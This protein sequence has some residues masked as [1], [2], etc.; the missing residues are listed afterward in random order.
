VEGTHRITC[1]LISEN[2]WEH[3]YYLRD[4]QRFELEGTDNTLID[5]HFSIPIEDMLSFIGDVEQE[6]GTY[7]DGY[8]IKITPK[9]NGII[10]YGDDEIPIDSSSEITFRLSGNSL[11]L[12]GHREF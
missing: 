2:S 6:L 12:V 8:I 11:E 4:E 10:K 5:G 9:L 1:R 3:D 7:S